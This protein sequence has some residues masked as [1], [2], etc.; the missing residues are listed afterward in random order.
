MSVQKPNKRNLISPPGSSDNESSKVCVSRRSEAN[1][2]KGFPIIIVILFSAP[3][4]SS[5]CY[6]D[7]A[8][9]R[10]QLVYY[11]IVFPSLCPERLDSPP[12][13]AIIGSFRS[14][15]KLCAINAKKVK[16]T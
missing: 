3:E 5:E 16:K 9:K 2:R 8:R 15:K 7:P 13:D 10:E 12:V 4:N 11:I 1:K 14:P 6:P